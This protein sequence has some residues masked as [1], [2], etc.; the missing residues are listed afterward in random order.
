MF[1][2]EYGTHVRQLRNRTSVAFDYTVFDNILK[3]LKEYLRSVARAGSNPKPPFY[4]GET[5]NKK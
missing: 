3:H 5:L 4:F 2:I 1:A